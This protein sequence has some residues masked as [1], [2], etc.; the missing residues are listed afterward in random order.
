M[1]GRALAEAREALP[2]DSNGHRI[3]EGGAVRTIGC[4]LN[5][6]FCIH[7][8]GPNYNC[9]ADADYETPDKLLASA[10]AAAMKRA[11]EVGAKTVGFA[12]LSAGVFRGN[13]S[14]ETILRI[15]VGAIKAS[16]YD[17]LEEVHMLAFN[18]VECEELVAA[19]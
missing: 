1:G 11:E 4:D 5:A 9:Y 3:P 2:E 7:A 14:L 18:Q 10:Y 15:G 12:L 16:S 6:Q 17:V 8:V 19:A 13:R